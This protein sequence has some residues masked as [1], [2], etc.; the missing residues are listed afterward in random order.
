MSDPKGFNVPEGY[1]SKD[2]DDRRSEEKPT[3]AERAKGSW[4]HAW[5]ATK[6]D[7]ADMRQTE[8]IKRGEKLDTEFKQLGDKKYP[9]FKKGGVVKKTGLVYAHKGE[10]ILPKGALKRKAIR[11]KGT[12]RK[13]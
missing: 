8:K 4:N 13:K 9:T 7:W 6:E 3:L 2:V 11:R 10:V 12:G 1:K 5:Q